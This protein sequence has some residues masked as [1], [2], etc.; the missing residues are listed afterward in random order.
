MRLNVHIVPSGLTPIKPFLGFIK[1]SQGLHKDMYK[2]EQSTV[3]WQ[4]R[5]IKG[6]TDTQANINWTATITLHAACICSF[7]SCWP[8]SA[9]L[10][11]GRLRPQIRQAINPKMMAWMTA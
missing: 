5:V 8:V 9:Y 2:S 1:F 11:C 3:V 6:C 4:K 10:L 7:P